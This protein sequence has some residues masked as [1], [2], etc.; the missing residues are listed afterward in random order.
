[1]NI[2]QVKSLSNG[3][4]GV[5]VTGVVE[6]VFDPKS[7]DGQYGPWTSQSFVIKDETGELLCSLSNRQIPKTL[8][9]K[10][11]T[12]VNGSVRTYLKDEET[13]YVLDLKKGSEIFQDE[14]TPPAEAKTSGESAVT[15]EEV[16]VPKK[17]TF[18]ELMLEA[19][20]EIHDVLVDENFKK[21]W[22][23]MAVGDMK[24]DDARAFII[25]NIISK[26]RG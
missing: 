21:M 20:L 22:A 6:R 23:D 9:G 2:G 26:Q 12:L 17:K 24:S 7:H 16:K 5:E 10:Q 13:Q 25:S 18:A 1:M 14:A 11:V 19:T 3:I 15:T 4:K 8:I